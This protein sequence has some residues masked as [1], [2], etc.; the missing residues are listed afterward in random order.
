[1]PRHLISDAHEW[2]NEIPTVPIYYARAR[3]PV[4]AGA[5]P[6]RS[7]T[8]M[9]QRLMAIEQEM[10][11]AAITEQVPSHVA[12]R[13]LDVSAK[14]QELVMTMYGKIVELEAMVRT[15]P[16]LAA[17]TPA[18][19]TVAATPAVRAGAPIA[20]PRVRKVAE[21]WSAIVTSNNPAETPQQVAE[22]VRKEVAPALGV[23]VHEVRELKRGGAMIRTPSVGEIRK[24]VGNPKFKE[25]GLEVKQNA[26]LKPKV[27]VMNV[28]SHLTVK[29]FMDGLFTNHFEEHMSNVAFSKSVTI[30][31]KP[32][33][34]DAGPTV[35]ITLELDQKALDILEE[36][37][38]IYVEYFSFR[39]RPMVRTYACHRCVGFDHKVAQCRVK[40]EVCRQ[41]GQ[42]GHRAA[43]CSNPVRCRNCSFRG[44]PAEHHML[45]AACPIYGA[46]LARVASRH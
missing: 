7:S 10:R 21:T 5:E 25:V 41:C 29:K 40:E 42:G 17:A 44:L 37:D 16:Q 24:V 2:I 8:A 46:L 34:S 20:A 3:V 38:R 9:V 13:V 27:M 26:A 45:S 35:N 33:T 1:M 19:A 36:H 43:K 4:S 31:S 15:R 6:P 23:R 12:H 39:W 28:D 32:W 11:K 22:R 18:A 14:Y 30:E